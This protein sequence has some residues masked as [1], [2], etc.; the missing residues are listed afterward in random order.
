M[1]PMHT[2]ARLL[3]QQA[4]EDKPNKKR[5]FSDDRASANLSKYR[6]ASDPKKNRQM[7]NIYCNICKTYEKLWSNKTY[8]EQYQSLRKGLVFKGRAHGDTA[9]DSYYTGSGG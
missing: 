3:V 1:H 5:R 9:S 8:Y 4:I 7:Q 2:K 6:Q